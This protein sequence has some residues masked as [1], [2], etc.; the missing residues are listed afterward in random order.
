M[1]FA[2]YI[3]RGD[4]ERRAHEQ[5]EHRL[6]DA[7]VER[8][9][10]ERDPVVELELVL[11]LELLVL[12]LVAEQQRRSGSRSQVQIPMPMKILAAAA[13]STT[14]W[15]L[16]GRGGHR[17][18]SSGR[19]IMRTDEVDGEQRDHEQRGGQA[20]LVAL[21][22]ADA[23]DRAAR[24]TSRARSCCPPSSP[25]PRA[26]RRTPPRGAASACWTIALEH[27]G[28]A[29]DD[30]GGDRQVRPSRKIG[31]ATNTSTTRSRYRTNAGTLSG[32]SGRGLGHV[33]GL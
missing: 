8:P 4:R 31:S 24:R 13:Q 5:V 22:D 3:H 23:E 1:R 17:A 10:L 18:A 15:L 30:V 19:R 12:A 11:G 29:A 9:D 2:M 28:A 16:G 32:G 33:R 27:P 7:H 21:R 26:G 6:V 20:G 25:P 14:A